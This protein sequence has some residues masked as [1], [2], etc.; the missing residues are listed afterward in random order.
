[1]SD[2]HVKP[3]LIDP[4]TGETLSKSEYKRRLKAASKPQK[5]VQEISIKKKEVEEVEIV[6]PT[7]YFENRCRQIEMLR[8]EG[9]DPYPHKFHVGI[10]MEQYIEK[11]SYLGKGRVKTDRRVP[12]TN[13]INRTSSRRNCHSSRKIT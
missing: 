13:H 10:G 1:M 5:Q 2:T 3:S 7:Q 9:T 12:K 8:K 6:D 11:Y 4:I